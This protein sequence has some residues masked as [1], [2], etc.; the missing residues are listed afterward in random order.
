MKQFFFPMRIPFLR[1]PFL[2]VKGFSPRSENFLMLYA[3]WVTPPSFVVLLHTQD[4]RT[5]IFHIGSQNFPS[6][7]G[8]FLMA[9]DAQNLIQ[10]PSVKL[11]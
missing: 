2:L 4:G 5:K 10:L 3:G 9:G 8:L 11:N 6:P 7:G 1:I